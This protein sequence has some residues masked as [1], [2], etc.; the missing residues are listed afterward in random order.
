MLAKYPNQ[1]D[2]VRNALRLYL[3]DI[4]TEKIQGFR[5]AFK[6]L[7]SGQEDIKVLFERLL[8]KLPDQ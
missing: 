7:L 6:Q 1:A 5:V 3:Y 4:T 8:S 2:V